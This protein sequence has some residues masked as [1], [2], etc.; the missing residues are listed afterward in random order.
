MSV[1][2]MCIEH[3][4]VDIASLNITSCGHCNNHGVSII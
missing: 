2:Q 1:V 4:C 3:R